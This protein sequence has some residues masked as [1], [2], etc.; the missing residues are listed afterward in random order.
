VVISNVPGPKEALYLDGARMS[1]LY[2][3]SIVVDHVALNITF[4]SYAGNLN[5]GVIACRHAIPDMERF[6]QHF[7][8]ALAELEGYV[9]ASPGK[10]QNS[11]TQGR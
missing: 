11:L 10:V 1:G 9:A 8:Q 3:V 2:P 5:F 4:T 6:I 7:E